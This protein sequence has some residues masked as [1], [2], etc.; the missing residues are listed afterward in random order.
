M[1]RDSQKSKVYRAERLAWWGAQ[2][3][4]YLPDDEFRTVAQCLALVDQITSSRWWKNRCR[5][6][7]VKV[8]DGRGTRFARAGHFGYRSRGK[9]G[10]GINLPRWSRSKPVI[11]HELAHI[12]TNGWHRGHGRHF[13]RNYLAL[14]SRWMG[15]EAAAELRSAFKTCR[16][17]W[18]VRK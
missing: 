12:M 16:V 10:W 2:D 6:G 9:N 5:I 13:C 1:P 18:H 15:K 11:L 7:T 3:S 8:F 14:V 4:P 17:K